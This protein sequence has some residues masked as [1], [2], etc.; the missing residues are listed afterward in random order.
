MQMKWAQETSFKNINKILS[1]SNFKKFIILQF[2]QSF[3]VIKMS[4]A[5]RS[6]YATYCA[7]VIYLENVLYLIAEDRFESPGAK[8][9]VCKSV[10]DMDVAAEHTLA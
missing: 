2:S 4:H 7:S 10:G 9:S 6:L 3:Q 8:P 1:T 5:S